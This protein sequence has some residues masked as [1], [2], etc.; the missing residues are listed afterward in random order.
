MSTVW[1]P[2][3]KLPTPPIDAVANTTVDFWATLIYSV[4]SLIVFVYGLYFWKR[5]GRPI[6]LLLMLGGAL[7][8]AVEPFVNVVGAVWHPQVNQVAVFEIMGRSMPWF[9][10]TG[11]VFYFG[12]MGSLT[13]LMFEKGVST[14]MF[15]V[16]ACVPMVVDVIMEEL[17]LYWDL[18][19][20]YGDQPL[21]L[22]WKLPLWWVPC[23]SLGELLGVSAVLLA[24][25]LLQG[26][27]VLLIPLLIPVCDAIAYAAISLPS[28]IV[29]NTEGVPFWLNQLGGIA[30]WLL[31]L[32]VLY[33]LSQ[34]VPKDSPLAKRLGSTHGSAG[35]DSG[36]TRVGK[37][38]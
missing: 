6:I 11:Y 37:P 25:P 38:A 15:W 35:N 13:Y 14:R 29:V 18:Y 36:M 27:R 26:W 34:V 3:F 24:K 8:S 20:Y 19:I 12:A 28:W 23:N 30:T 21:I 5:T 10:V 7:C 9:L 31:A 1:D 32:M 33:V 4:L 2:T 22:L 16:F 17:M